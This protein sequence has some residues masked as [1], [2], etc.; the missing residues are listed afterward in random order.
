MTELAVLRSDDA[1]W[2]AF[3]AGSGVPSHLQTTAWARAKAPNGWRPIRVVADGGSGPIGAQVLMRK[4]GPG[5]FALGYAARGPVGTAFDQAS[6]AAFSDALRRAA[7]RH[8]LTHVTVDPALEGEAPAELLRA[9]G[10]K[11]AD[12]VQHDR[13]R[14]I[15]LARPES[16]LWSDLRS[17]ARRYVNKARKAGCTVREGGAVDLEAFFAIMVETAQRSGFIHRSADAYRVTYEAFSPTDDARLLFAHLPDG[18]PAAAKMLLSCGGR[19]MQPYSGMTGAGGESRANYLLEWETIR[20]ASARGETV[21]DMWGLAHPGIAQ[22]KAGF[23][24]R[25]V[26]Y[27]GTW[28]LETLPFLRDALV[29]GRRSYVRLARWRRGLGSTDA[30]GRPASS[31]G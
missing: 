19:V 15:D 24:G 12:P 1:A 14:L 27:C 25:E 26:A 29:Q 23:G 3:V 2:D 18:T 6:V 5:P 31:D 13:S 20:Q 11:P 16:E 7:K 17:T 22:F 4:L 28:D 10:W 9:A 21:Y 8:R 30:S